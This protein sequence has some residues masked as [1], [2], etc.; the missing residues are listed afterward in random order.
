MTEQYVS[1]MSKGISICRKFQPIGLDIFSKIGKSKEAKEAC[2]KLFLHAAANL[3]IQILKALENGHLQLG[4]VGLRSL[5]E[6]SVNTAYIF[7]HPK[8]QRDKNRANKIST[9]YVDLIHSKD[10]V[11]HTVLDKKPF[12]SR[13]EEVGLGDV[14]NR[15]YRI[16]SEWAHLQGKTPYLYDQAYGEK[17]GLSVAENTLHAL[18]NIFDSVCSFYNF[19]LDPDLER[20]VA[21]YGKS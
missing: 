9:E 21:G 17:F 15:N 6:M 11:N 2:A 3:S 14:Y 20:E 8:F 12:K 19:N 4:V 10:A 16:L 13:A 18:R 1:A 7:N 5:F